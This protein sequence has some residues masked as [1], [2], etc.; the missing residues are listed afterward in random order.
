ML[1]RHHRALTVPNICSTV[2][3]GFVCFFPVEIFR[4]YTRG[5]LFQGIG[6]RNTNSVDVSART[7]PKSEFNRYRSSQTANRLPFRRTNASRGRIVDYCCGARRAIVNKA[8]SRDCRLK[9][10]HRSYIDIHTNN[11]RSKITQN[12][13]WHCPL[14]K[15][16][17][18]V[19][20]ILGDFKFYTKFGLYLTTRQR[21]V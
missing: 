18:N 9:N 16:V 10:K 7:Y 21:R 19:V 20:Y 17:F 5:Y 3:I 14:K 1:W 8:N 12:A 2:Y 11:N 6:F 13:Y 15:R 4:T